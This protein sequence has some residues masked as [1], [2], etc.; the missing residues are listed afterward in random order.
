MSSLSQLV[1]SVN[2]IGKVPSALC[3][4]IDFQ[5]APN[6]FIAT[7]RAYY[8]TY[9]QTTNIR[10]NPTTYPVVEQSEDTLES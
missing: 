5:F 4:K 6:F 8:F 3:E 7:I 10:Y 1:L 2:R 9:V